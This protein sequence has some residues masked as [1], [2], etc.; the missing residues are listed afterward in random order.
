MVYYF[1]TETKL[2]IFKCLS[3]KELRSIKQTNLYFRDFIEKY[4]GELAREKVYSIHF[5]HTIN[6]F[7]KDLHKLNKPKSKNFDFPLNEQLE[8]KINKLKYAKGF[9]PLLTRNSQN[10]RLRR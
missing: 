7:K 1:P 3:Y 4:E 9:F 6:Q 5:D 10:F 2:D 8:E